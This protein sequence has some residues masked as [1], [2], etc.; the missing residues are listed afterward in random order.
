[1]DR[2][3]RQDQRRHLD[4]G[5]RDRCV[6]LRERAGRSVSELRDLGRCR[7]GGLRVLVERLPGMAD[8]HRDNAERGRRQLKPFGLALQTFV[9]RLGSLVL[10]FGELA[11]VAGQ[12]ADLFPI[13]ARVPLDRDQDLGAVVE[14]PHY[15]LPLGGFSMRQLEHS[16][17]APS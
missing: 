8:R 3:A 11:F 2:S 5:L 16:F 12:F 17:I 15:R 1:M 6:E 4:H 14:E 9:V 7:L 13:V 10:F